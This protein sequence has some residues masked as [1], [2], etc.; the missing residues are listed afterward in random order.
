LDDGSLGVASVPSGASVGD[1]EVKEIRDS[2]PSRFDGKGVLVAV[3]NIIEYIF[4]ALK[5]LEALDQ[6]KVDNV[7]RQL[8]G[9]DDKS[10]LGANSILS[11]SLGVAVAAATSQR[12][13]LYKYVRGK[14]GLDEANFRSPVPMANLIEGGRHAKGGL[15]FQEF[16]VI[17]KNQNSFEESFGKINQVIS[18]LKRVMD[19]RKLEFSIGDE[20]G[21][22]LNLPTNEE[23]IF[24]LQ[25]ALKNTGFS[26]NEFHIG[27]DIA[28]NT[29]FNHGA[30][31]IR[32]VEAPLSSSSLIDFLEGLR[33]KHNLFSIEDPLDDEDWSGWEQIKST[34][35]NQVLIIAD[36]FTS[37]RSDRLA[38]VIKEKLADGVIVKP[39][40]IGTLT[41]TL[42]FIRDAR[43]AALKV[44]VSHRS[45]ETE[46][47]FVA[48]LAVAASADFVKIG[49]PLQKER[50]RKYER[51][52]KIDNE[53]RESS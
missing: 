17:P 3:S 8:D 19:A 30:Y 1:Y 23:A 45:G 20:G 5:G 48:D 51:L 39:N 49:C 21:F 18:G 47:T 2:N 7:M 4:P 46:D 27:L 41:E 37:T 44:I 26:S 32:D 52:I 15:D 12:L 29:I 34:L 10:R 16:L 6:Y 11:V 9:T 22:A 25:E 42:D 40:Q 28:G 24:I 13:P 50:L 31:K 14:L 53:I 38:K 36:D 33:S 43:E 35:G